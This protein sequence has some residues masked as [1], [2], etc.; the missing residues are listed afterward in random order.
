[1]GGWLLIVPGALISLDRGIGDL[2]NEKL[3][4]RWL[5]RDGSAKLEE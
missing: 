5:V 1:M 3:E 4:C 2:Y